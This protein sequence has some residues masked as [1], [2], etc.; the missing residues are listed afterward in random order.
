MNKLIETAVNATVS[1]C[2]SV[3]ARKASGGVR[4]L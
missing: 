4:I 1:N 2:A 3:D